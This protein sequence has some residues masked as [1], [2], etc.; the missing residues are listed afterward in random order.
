MDSNS[1]PFLQSAARTGSRRPAMMF[2]DIDSDHGLPGVIAPSSLSRV[3]LVFRRLVGCL[4]PHLHPVVDRIPVV[5][6]VAAPHRRR[7]DRVTL[8]APPTRGAMAR[9][10]ETAVVAALGTGPRRVA[11]LVMTGASRATGALR[12]DRVVTRSVPGHHHAIGPGTDRAVAAARIA[13]KAMTGASHATAA[14]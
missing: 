10:R 9:R 13:P 12:V 14:T 6:R 7:I 5:V 8:V 2:W 4:L 11:Q 1:A 3:V